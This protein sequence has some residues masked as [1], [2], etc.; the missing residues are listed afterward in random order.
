[1]TFTA[2]G[3]QSQGLPSFTIINDN[4]ALETI[5]QYD[6]SFS[7]PSITN[8]VTLGPNTTILITDDDG[9]DY[10]NTGKD[11]GVVYIELNAYSL[12]KSICSSTT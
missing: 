9:N 2:H 4:V 1:M 11:S 12:L 10:N 5:E 3:P 7:N 6:L 8:S